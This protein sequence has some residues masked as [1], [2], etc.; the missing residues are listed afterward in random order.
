M[1]ERPLIE[2]H[3]YDQ[4]APSGGAVT[5]TGIGEG[6]PA[7]SS[8]NFWATDAGTAGWYGGQWGYSY[9]PPPPNPVDQAFAG[10]RWR[11][12]DVAFLLS[13]LN[14]LLMLLTILAY[15]MRD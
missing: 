7:A 11:R 14:L 12:E 2:P 4:G 13:A 3:D 15:L 6:D 9:Q 8:S 1:Y 10:T 5:R